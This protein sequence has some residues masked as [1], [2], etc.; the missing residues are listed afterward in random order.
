MEY[1]D[2]LKNLWETW[3]ARLHES[4]DPNDVHATFRSG[5]LRLAYS[6]ARMNVLS[7]GFQYAFGKASIG[8]DATLLFRVSL[9]PC[10]APRPPD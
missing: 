9:C 6:Y 10:P 4:N 8:Q 3:S 5:L 2:K 7:F 1:D